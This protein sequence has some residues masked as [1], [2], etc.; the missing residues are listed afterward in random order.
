MAHAASGGYYK[1]DIAVGDGFLPYVVFANSPAEALGRL[2]AETGCLVSS[3]ELEGPCPRNGGAVT[4]SLSR[5]FARHSRRHHS[6][7]R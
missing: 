2:R 5:T 6:S 4:V 3:G 7:K 1:A